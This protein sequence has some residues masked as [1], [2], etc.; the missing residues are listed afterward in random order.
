MP[1]TEV[2]LYGHLGRR[3]GRVHRFDIASPAE[4]VRA[5]AANFPGFEQA[6]VDH[7]PGFHMLAGRDDVA[8]PERLHLPA[9]SRETIKI[10][11]VVAG[12]KSGFLSIILGVAMIAAA[13]FTGGV[14]L[15][16]FAGAGGASFLGTLAVGFGASLILG[17]VAQL[18]SPQPKYSA[19]SDDEDSKQQS[20]MFNGPIN[21]T[22]QGVPVPIGYGRLIVGSAV[23]SMGITTKEMPT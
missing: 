19:G 17:G 12:S 21:T 8:D 11:P 5:L 20:Y 10:V 18:L 22:S 3:F 6:V 4:A 7:E 16:Y 13:F 9:S 1:L 14:S 15:A 23:V 2:R